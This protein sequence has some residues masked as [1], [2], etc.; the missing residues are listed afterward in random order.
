MTCQLTSYVWM[1]RSMGYT[2]YLIS[3]SPLQC[4]QVFIPYMNSPKYHFLLYNCL[5]L[6]FSINNHLCTAPDSIFPYQSLSGDQH[7]VSKA[8]NFAL[9]FLRWGEHFNFYLGICYNHVYERPAVWVANRENPIISPISSEL[10][11]TSD[12]NIVLFDQSKTQVWSTN[13]T[14][15]S[16]NSTVA[17]LLDSGNLFLQM[18]VIRIRSFG[19]AAIA[20]PI[21]GFLVVTLDWIEWLDRTTGSLLGNTRMILP[22]VSSHLR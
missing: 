8:G 4:S 14:S 15:I 18:G 1:L 21:H 2:W 5:I 17:V 11:I 13:S 10:K 3:F 9:G 6:F 19:R 20:Q 12:G 16:S 7:I 22:L